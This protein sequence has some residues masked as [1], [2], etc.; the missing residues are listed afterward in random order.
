MSSFHSVG[1]SI[2]QSTRIRENIMY[3]IVLK[4]HLAQEFEIS[5]S[6]RIP[7]TIALSKCF[8]SLFWFVV[9]FL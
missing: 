6:I 3:Q 2:A 1:K 4:I 5:P 7:L 8:K 9:C